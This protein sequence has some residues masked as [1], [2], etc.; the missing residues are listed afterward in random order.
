MKER[1]LTFTDLDENPLSVRLKRDR[2][3]LSVYDSHPELAADELRGFVAALFA[4]YLAAPLVARVEAAR[5]RLHAARP[6]RRGREDAA[7]EDALR[8]L[9]DVVA[10]ITDGGLPVARTPSA[11]Y[12]EAGTLAR[13]RRSRAEDAG[14]MLGWGWLARRPA[15]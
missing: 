3:E 10:A 14:E 12:P 15:I 9:D 6:A 13:G 5:D 11:A 4:E 7:I 8:A 1:Q 2:I